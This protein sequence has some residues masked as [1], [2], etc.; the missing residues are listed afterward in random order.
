MV[1]SED[2]LRKKTEY[3]KTNGVSPW[4]LNIGYDILKELLE[5]TGDDRIPSKVNGLTVFVSLNG[6]M[7]VGS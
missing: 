3:E 7:E 1:V 2:I 4:R 5:E 6:V